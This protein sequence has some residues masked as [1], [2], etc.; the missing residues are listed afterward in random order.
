MF[1]PSENQGSLNFSERFLLKIWRDS[2]KKGIT[3]KH[4]KR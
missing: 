3:K 2:N 4:D 1:Q